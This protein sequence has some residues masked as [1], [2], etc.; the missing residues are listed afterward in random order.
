[1]CIFRVGISD[2]FQDIKDAKEE[3]RK[4]KLN[5]SVNENLDVAMKKFKTEFGSILNK[6]S[7]CDTITGILESNSLL[8]EPEKSMIRRKLLVY[9]GSVEM[10]CYFWCRNQP[11]LMSL[12]LL[13]ANQNYFH[14][15]SSFLK[16][17]E[18]E[19]QQKNLFSDL[20]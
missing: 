7:P 8:T 20:L 3:Q 1:M 17:G 16:G 18:D 12:N 15:L 9:T 11:C 19:L 10:G 6:S 2:V 4:R 14:M 5:Q 13:T